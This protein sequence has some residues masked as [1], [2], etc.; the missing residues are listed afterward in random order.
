MFDG[1][2]AVVE[3][4]VIL[5]NVLDQEIQNIQRGPPIKGTTLRA[6]LPGGK[7]TSHWEA[8]G[9]DP[10]AIGQVGGVWYLAGA[11][12]LCMDYDT[13][14]RPV[15]PYVFFK[16]AAQRWER[17]TADEF[18]AAISKRNLT[19]PGSSNHRAVVGTGFISA[20]QGSRLNPGVRSDY[21]N[22]IIRSRP[23]PAWEE[24]REHLEGADR[25]WRPAS[26]AREG[27]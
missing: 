4:Q 20:E 8:M 24:C 7:W 15:P 23:V 13:W 1:T 18:P 2:K 3:R 26:A 6:P 22:E 12:G 11:P 27:K 19:F 14:G 9:L 21:L 10:I 16:Y 25:R 5:G 17:I